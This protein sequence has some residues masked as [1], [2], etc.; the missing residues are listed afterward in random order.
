MRA[1]ETEPLMIA[2][3]Y[4]CA[5][6]VPEGDRFCRRCGARQSHDLTPELRR[7]VA[8]V[9]R[10]LTGQV[11]TNLSGQLIVLV[12]QSLVRHAPGQG[13]TRGIRRMICTLIAIPIWMLIIVLSPIDAYCAARAA[14]GCVEYH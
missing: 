1:Q 2:R 3:C 7:T 9:T 11:A 4:A 5:S 8:C 6:E 12:A 10:P 14:S 13:S